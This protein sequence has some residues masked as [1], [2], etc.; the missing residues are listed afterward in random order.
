M[1]AYYEKYFEKIT[2]SLGDI[3]NIVRDMLVLFLPLPL[4][5]PLPPL[6]PSSPLSVCASYG[7]NVERWNVVRRMFLMHIII[8]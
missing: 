8:R 1:S 5:L 6:P 4:R 3:N 2:D 7:Q